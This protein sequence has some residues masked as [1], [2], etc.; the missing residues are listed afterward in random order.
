M[1]TASYCPNTP[2]E[3]REMLAVI[4]VASVEELFGA[5]PANLRAQ[6]FDLPAGMSE[7]ELL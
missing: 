3:I 1:S 6:S 7:F 2:E 5:I 4:G